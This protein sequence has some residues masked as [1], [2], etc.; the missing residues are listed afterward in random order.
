MR[1]EWNWRKDHA[2]RHKHG[3]CFETASLV[4]QDPFHLSVLE[5]YEGAEEIWQT[6]GLVGDVVLL[7]VA[8]TI[9]DA[10]GEEIIRIISARKA[11]ARERRRYEESHA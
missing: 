2:N 4:F 10:D 7:L 1:F 5:R 6:L 11:T 3:L 8:H 9:E